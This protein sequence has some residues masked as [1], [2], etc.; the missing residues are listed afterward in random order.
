MNQ[1]LRQS[2]V[3]TISFGPVSVEG[4]GE[5]WAGSGLSSVVTVGSSGAAVIITALDDVAT[6]IMLSKNGGTLTMREQGGN[7]VATVYDAHGCFKV[8]LSAIDTGTLGRLRVIHTSATY[9][10]VYQDFM[11]AP[12]QVWDS[13]FG[14]DKLDVNVAE[15]ANIDFGVLQK[16]SLNAATPIVTGFSTPANV[17]DAVFALE[18]YGDGNW[19]EQGGLTKEAIRAEMDTNSTKLIAIKAKTDTLGGAG[20][21]TWTYTLTDTG[22]GLLPIAYADVWVS[23]DVLGVNI[24]A[25]SRTNAAGIVTFYLDAGTVYIWRQKS[26]YEFTNPDTEVI[27]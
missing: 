7:F 25:V 2:T 24:I 6:G 8:S 19:A 13:L 26:G 27:V 3:A 4:E 23:T 12:Q 17:T 1:I 10:P 21:I 11:V 18:T 22:P 20:A 14:S 15:Q 9:L 5:R 16:L